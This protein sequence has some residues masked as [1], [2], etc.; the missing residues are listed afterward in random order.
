MTR[1]HTLK[2]SA[3]LLLGMLAIPGQAADLDQTARTIVIQEGDTLSEIAASVLE[4]R[5]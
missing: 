3:C 1:E 5:P 4:A 2:I